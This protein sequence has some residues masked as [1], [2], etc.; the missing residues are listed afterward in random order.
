MRSAM[1]AASLALAM[2]ACARPDVPWSRL[3]ARYAS[4]QS[5]FAD[6][7]EGVRVHYRDQGPPTA[8]TVVLVHG[9]SASLHA[10]EPWV[11]RLAKE[12]RVVTLDL[13]AHGLT[14]TPPDYQVSTEGH[15]AVVEALTR[16]L[17]VRQFVL[18]GNSMG[19]GV[20]WNFALAHPEQLRGLV[21]V[22]AVGWP[23]EGRREG[24]PLVFKLLA[25]PAGRAVLKSI[26]V[27]PMAERGLKQAYLDHG[28]VTPELVD[29][30]VEMSSA[31]GR[32]DL[33][34]KAQSTPRTPVTAATFA[35]ITTPTLVMSG[36]KD[37]LIP[38][39][40]AR[41]LAS[42]IPNARLIVYPDVGHVPMEQIPERSAA[43][44]R[45]FLATLPPGAE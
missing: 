18:G 45:A 12:Y 11:E 39:A 37:A 36:E 2:T 34:L 21:L 31:P 16:R 25:N 33:I 32:K 24:A 44:L 26:D 19:G 22:D 40:S 42:A 13:P 43:D 7:P 3:E 41:G 4:A 14:Q 27:R 8:P 28:L 15:V 5:Q 20:A 10:W 35:R 9:F 23:S 1:F 30:Y 17:D 6:L 29:R 38:V